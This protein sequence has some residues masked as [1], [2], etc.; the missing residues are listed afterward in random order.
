VSMMA[1]ICLRVELKHS[2]WEQSPIL[3]KHEN[4]GA[5][6]DDDKPAFAMFMLPHNAGLL[7]LGRYSLLAD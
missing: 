4:N 2:F 6:D 3:A 5:D 7:L 1:C